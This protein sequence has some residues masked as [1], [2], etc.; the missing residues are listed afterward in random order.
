MYI[1]RL[2]IEKMTE[3]VYPP[4]NGNCMIYFLNECEGENRI[5]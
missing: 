5:W 1:K 3:A 4:N 2:R